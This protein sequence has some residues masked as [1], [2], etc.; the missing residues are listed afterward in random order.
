MRLQQA[1][2]QSR[3]HHRALGRSL[4]WCAGRGAPGRSWNAGVAQRSRHPTTDL[5]EPPCLAP[6]LAPGGGSPDSPRAAETGTL[7]PARSSVLVGPHALHGPR[8]K[9]GSW[10]RPPRVTSPLPGTSSRWMPRAILSRNH[11]KLFHLTALPTSPS[12]TYL[13]QSAQTLQWRGSSQAPSGAYCVD[14]REYCNAI[15]K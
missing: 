8:T 5:A 14:E 11:T 2:Q 3:H 10:T 7:S 12:L 6:C 15:C 4:R 9:H 1:M 13:Q